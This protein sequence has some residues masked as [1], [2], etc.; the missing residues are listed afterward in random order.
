MVLDTTVLKKVEGAV[1]HV[2]RELYKKRKYS[3]L[4]IAHARNM[5][6]PSCFGLFLFLLILEMNAASFLKLVEKLMENK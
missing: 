5:V 6:T 3:K 1:Q 4:D 2:A